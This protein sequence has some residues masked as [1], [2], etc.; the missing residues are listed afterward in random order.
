MLSI[1][2]VAG[3][4]LGSI[5][6]NIIMFLRLLMFAQDGQV[7]LGEFLSMLFL[8][9]SARDYVKTL[10]KEGREPTLLDTVLYRLNKTFCWL[11]LIGIIGVI[12]GLIGQ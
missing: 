9:G 4:L 1:I 10:R 8:S 2:L 7:V 11:I 5:L 3:G 6:V 12:A